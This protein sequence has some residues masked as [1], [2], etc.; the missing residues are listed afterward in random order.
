MQFLPVGLVPVLELHRTYPSVCKRGLD[1]LKILPSPPF[2]V[3]VL[4]RLKVRL[5]A[6][7]DPVQLTVIFDMKELYGIK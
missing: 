7:S 2:T 4:M 6:R 1:A 5:G 3:K